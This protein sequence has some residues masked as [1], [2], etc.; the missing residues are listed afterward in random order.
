MGRVSTRS[1]VSHF[2]S[3]VFMSLKYG[4]EDLKSYVVIFHSSNFFEII[5]SMNLIFLKKKKTNFTY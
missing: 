2:G 3:T 4:F 5:D 1:T